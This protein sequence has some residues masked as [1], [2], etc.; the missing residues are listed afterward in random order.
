[1]QSDRASGFVRS[2]E[3]L[4]PYELVSPIGS[5]GMGEVWKARDTRL[6]RFVAIKVSKEAFHDRFLRE[7]RTI[8]KLD[9]PHI[10][11]LYDIGE[12]YLVMEL[13]EGERLSGP[14]PLKTALTYAIEICGALFEAHRVGIIHRDLKPANIFVT[15]NGIVLLDFG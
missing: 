10:C 9:H 3:R 4:G 7:A 11:R 1:M 14:L 6:A 15:R 5:G 2:G 12:N 13:L 8:A